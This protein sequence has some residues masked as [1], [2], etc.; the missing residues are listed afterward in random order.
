[1][2]NVSPSTR[3]CKTGVE[4]NDPR[5]QTRQLQIVHISDIHFG[6][7]HRFDPP[8]TAAGDTPKRVGYPSLLQKLQ[9]DLPTG[10]V[11]CPAIV[12]VTG[13]LATTAVKNEFDEA[14]AL[15]QGTTTLFG[16]LVDSI[17]FS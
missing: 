17:A 15:V 12:C 2:T 13:D 6:K 14:E 7:D 1:M 10:D 9:E 8:R 16:V 4:S 3:G 11:G 5:H